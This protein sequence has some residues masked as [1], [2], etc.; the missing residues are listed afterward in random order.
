[1]TIHAIL[2]MA[3]MLNYFPT[4]QGI[5]SEICPRSILTGE[6]LDYKKNLTL[7]PG[8]YFQVHEDEVPS[9]SDKAINQGSICLGLCG[10]L[11]IGFNF[12]S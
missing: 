1:M 11:Q 2:K 9:N 8:Q 4:K 5:S 12:M 10:K 6:S 7:Q 3:K